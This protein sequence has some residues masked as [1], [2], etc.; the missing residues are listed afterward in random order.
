LQV[1]RD[2][3][4]KHGLSNQKRTNRCMTIDGL[5]EQIETTI[6]TTEK[7]FKLGELRILA[8]LFLLLLAPAGARPQSI[9]RIRFGDVRLA[10]A[11]DPEGGPHNVLIRF[12]L[13]FTKTYL[14][15]KDA[16]GCSRSHLWRVRR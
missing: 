12:T 16:Y 11:R 4:S 14:G 9:L 8:A 5:R 2:L 10:L 13:V 7:N 6:G 15:D 1:L 3:A